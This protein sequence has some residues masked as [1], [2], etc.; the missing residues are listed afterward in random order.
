MYKIVIAMFK[1]IK[2]YFIKIIG[3]LKYTHKFIKCINYIINIIIIRQLYHIA[4]DNIF[5]I[6]VIQ[7]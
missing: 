3:T 7:I 1:Q 6:Y 4:L 2:L 5:K